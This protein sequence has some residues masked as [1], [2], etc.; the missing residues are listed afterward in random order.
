VKVPDFDPAIARVLEAAGRVAT[1]ASDET[2][3]A[4]AVARRL[5]L[6]DDPAA[7]EL[8]KATDRIIGA[9]EQLRSDGLVEA[10]TGGSAYRLTP[11][12]RARVTGSRD[13]D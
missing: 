4:D 13:D 10:V 1:H 6:D 5:E 2:V 12:G 3:D 11:L 8:S 9:L 7:V